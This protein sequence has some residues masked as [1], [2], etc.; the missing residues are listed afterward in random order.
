[1]VDGGER[2]IDPAPP[3][4][5]RVALW[6]AKRGA[7]VV[8]LRP[9]LFASGNGK[10]SPAPWIR[11]QQEGPLRGRESILQFWE[12]VPDAQLAILLENGLAAIDVDIKHLPRG[13]AP[14]GRPIPEGPGYK[15][16]TKSGG[17]HFV[18]SVR[19]H[20]DSTRPTRVTGLAGYVDVFTGGLLIV[21]P[22]QFA[23]F[24]RG[25]EV[26]CKDI[27]IFPTMTEA[28]GAYAPW[29]P[30]AWM[31]RWESGAPSSIHSRVSGVTRVP[32]I[33]HKVNLTKIVGALHFLE[34]HPE[35]LTIFDEGIRHPDGAVDRSLTEFRLVSILKSQGFSRETCWDIVRLSPHT[36]SPQDLRGWHYY[37]KNVWSRLP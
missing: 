5:A 24:D 35:A 15:E 11:W 34:D 21:A 19:E 20:L 12:D 36:K 25:Y 1:M 37:Q 8:P 18:F 22:S 6:W 9:S 2:A 29:L 4:M 28:L 32:P 13:M 27:P 31:E 26:L 17:L 3:R 16:T 7:G 30:T 10:L 23:N 14:P 33:G